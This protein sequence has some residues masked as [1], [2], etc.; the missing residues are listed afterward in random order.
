MNR[1]IHGDG[2]R[3]SSAAWNRPWASMPS[4]TVVADA[5]GGE[6]GAHD[7]AVV[8]IGGL[9]GL[10][11]GDRFEQQAQLVDVGGLE[12][13]ELADPRATLGQDL[14][15]ALAGQALERLAQRGG[16]DRPP[17]GEVVGVQA[18]P[19]FELAS[20]DGVPELVLDPVGSGRGRDRRHGRMVPLARILYEL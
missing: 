5:E 8:V 4:S 11:Q 9:E 3:A 10:A 14:D 20:E 7:V 6:R 2:H 18:L 16:A 19:G 15:Q 17:L 13:G 1:S 12:G